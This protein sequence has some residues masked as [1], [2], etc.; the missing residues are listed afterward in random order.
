M[1]VEAES[2]LGHGF[3]GAEATVVFVKQTHGSMQ[4]ILGFVDSVNLALP[5]TSD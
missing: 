2:K 5:D 4:C 3:G 1:M